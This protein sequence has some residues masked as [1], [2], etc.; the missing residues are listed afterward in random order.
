MVYSMNIRRGCSGRH[1]RIP[2][3]AATTIATV[4]ISICF[5]WSG[6]FIVFQNLF[7]IPIILSCMFY[8]V[9]GFL[10][11]VCLALLYL[12]LMLVFG[13]VNSIMIPALMR[14]AIFIVVAGVVTFLSVERERQVMARRENELILRSLVNAT[15]EA[16]FLSDTQGRI[17]VAN[18]ITARRFGKTPGEVAGS[19]QYDLLPSHAAEKRRREL[20]EV[21]RTGKP[22]GFLDSGAERTDEVSMYPVFDRQGKVKR[23]AIFSK[24]VTEH[25]RIEEERV[26]LIG[27][28]QESLN[29]VKLLSG[30]IPICASCKKI[31]NDKGYWE[32]MEIYIRDHSEADFSHGICPDCSRRLYPDLYKDPQTE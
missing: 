21:V 25:R 13:S 19:S 6:S 15:D 31:R 1:L 16:L 9:R 4:V 27:E 18:E 20:G 30:L 32:Q 14:V 28:L 17:L 24:D 7:Y 11:S 3:V 23:V 8:G 10:Y 29:K 2:L 5:L 26:A 22:A 12:V